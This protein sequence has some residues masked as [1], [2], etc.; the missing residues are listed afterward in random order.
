MSEKKKRKNTTFSSL[1]YYN[2]RLWFSGALLSNIGTWVQRIGQDWLVMYILTKGNPGLSGLYGGIVTA[3]QFLPFLFLSPFTG[4]LA[5]RL[6]RRHLMLFTQTMMGLLALGLGLL[7]LN[8]QVTIYWVFAF[9]LLM[10]LVQALDN[11]VRQTFVGEMVE[12]KDLTNAV[13]LNSTSFNSARLIGPAVGGFL[14]AWSGP[15]WAFIINA[16]SFAATAGSLLL[17][18]KNEL[19]EL[20]SAQKKKGQIKEGL[21]YVRNRPDILIIM[22]VVSVVSMLGLNNQ[23]T[24]AQMAIHVFNIPE[25]SQYGLLGTFFAVGAVAGSLM[26]SR[27]Q[28]PRTRLVV[29]SALAFGVTSGIYAMMP[30]FY[31]FAIAGIA[32]GFCVLTLITSANATVQLGVTPAMRGRVM[33]LYMLVFQGVTPFG[34]IL[35]GWIAGSWG[36]NGPRWAIGIGSIAS[37]I[38]ALCAIYWTKRH[39]HYNIHLSLK[40]QPHLTLDYPQ[41]EDDR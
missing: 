30:N 35:V 37:I 36:V 14:I 27:R 5:D 15:G 12:K 24:Q 17:M 4:L 26:A 8:H 25:P 40:S 31:S 29:G 23:L 16:I 11:P 2:Y 10:G 28:R 3:L 13:G 41:P 33:S 7:T 38:V 39:W 32:V 21:R 9:A 18:R 1:S 22:G 34:S 19:Y 20:P 6:N